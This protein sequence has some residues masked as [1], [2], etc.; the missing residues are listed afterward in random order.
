MDDIDKTL[1]GRELPD[2]L[3]KGG[4]ILCT[5]GR[6]CV[7]TIDR[8]LALESRMIFITTPLIHVVTFV[9]SDDFEC[10]IFLDD[11]KIFYPVFQTISDTGIPLAI[12]REPCWGID[13]ELFCFIVSQSRRISEKSE[14]EGRSEKEQRLMSRHCAMIRQETMM[15][16]LMKHFRRPPAVSSQ[17]DSQN[18][19]A[20]QFI[21]RLHEN[22]RTQRSVSWYAEQARLSAG[23][24][25]VIVRK[26]S[27]MSPSA[28][29]S[30]VTVTYAKMLLERTDMSIKEIAAELNFPEQF[31]FRK[32]FRQ[33]VGI[34]PKEYRRRCR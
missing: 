33:N 22:Y 31:T 27:G 2:F 11:L 25:A 30:T 17:E 5:K 26:V 24:F 6:A 4:F 21:I 7:R 19:I 20:Y 1:K 12:R 9:P 28:W 29:I 34:P 10:V 32:Y 16:V 15:E 18:V 8:E 23:Y 3:G 14:T 13:E